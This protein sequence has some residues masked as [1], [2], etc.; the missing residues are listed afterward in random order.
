MPFKCGICGKQFLYSSGLQCPECKRSGENCRGGR[1]P[2]KANRFMD[3]DGEKMTDVPSADY[4]NLLTNS[5]RKSPQDASTTISQ[6]KSPGISNADV[7]GTTAARKQTPLSYNEEN[8]CMICGKKFQYLFILDSHLRAHSTDEIDRIL[9]MF[10]SSADDESMLLSWEPYACKECRHEFCTSEEM[11]THMLSHS[12]EEHQNSFSSASEPEAHFREHSNVLGLLAYT[13]KFCAK[14]FKK[15]YNWQIHMKTHTGERDY[16]CHFCAKTFWRKYNWKIHMKTHTGERAY[17][18]NY[19][20]KSFITSSRL[21]FHM[22]SKHSCVKLN[23][24]SAA[25]G[26]LRKRMQNSDESVPDDDVKSRKVSNL[27]Q[28][29]HKNSSFEKL[30][31]RCCDTDETLAM[32]TSTDAE[33]EYG[34]SKTAPL[35]SKI[36]EQIKNSNIQSAFIL[37]SGNASMESDPPRS[38]DSAINDSSTVTVQDQPVCNQTRNKNGSKS[39]CHRINARTPNSEKTKSVESGSSTFDDSVM[40][41]GIAGSGNIP[42][43]AQAISDIEICDSLD[44]EIN[45]STITTELMLDN[46]SRDENMVDKMID[47]RNDNRMYYS[48]SICNSKYPTQETLEEHKNLHLKESLFECVECGQEDVVKDWKNQDD[49]ELVSGKPQTSD[50]TYCDSRQSVMFPKTPVIKYGYPQIALNKTLMKLDSSVQPDVARHVPLVLTE[51]KQMTDEC[52]QNDDIPTEALTATDSPKSLFH[53]LTLKK[54]RLYECKVCKRRFVNCDSCRYHM[55]THIDQLHWCDMCDNWFNFASDLERHK[56]ALHPLASEEESSP[57]PLVAYPSDVCHLEWK[58]KELLHQHKKTRDHQCPKCD[59]AFSN[60]PLYQIHFGICTG[61]EVDSK[62]KEP[63]A[64]VTFE[65]FE[66]TCS[67]PGSDIED[68]EQDIEN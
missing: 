21:K 36:A 26:N 31:T 66:I 6:G 53:K 48:C 38:S 41:F 64:S 59:R 42:D 7:S 47:T 44:P 35:C 58:S 45:S 30:M 20:P 18:C 54:K 65:G 2:K 39:N 15:K 37:Q 57:V 12:A 60:D 32:Q 5:E 19:C 11:K 27:S 43:D 10:Q 13:C 16:F 34:G 68:E 50:N 8:E 56:L 52:K 4:M 46:S 33:Q 28:D 51:E 14:T 24:G 62:A 17:S 55:K 29:S 25:S 67:P 22:K 63:N 23:V 61:A 9:K 3:L 1:R 40:S 49:R